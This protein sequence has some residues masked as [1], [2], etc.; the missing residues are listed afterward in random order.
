MNMSI[1]ENNIGAWNNI[2]DNL[3]VV[4]ASV[5]GS[6]SLMS[7]YNVLIQRAISPSNS[8]Q[9]N[10]QT[11]VSGAN[12][13]ARIILYTDTM[14]NRS[15]SYNARVLVHELGHAFNLGHPNEYGPSCNYRSIMYQS[16]H[17]LQTSK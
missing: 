3:E 14:E 15:S 13:Y 12:P 16:S 11:T 9:T 6:A 17:A 10:A 7:V 1:Y 5:T 2:T 4:R 8:T